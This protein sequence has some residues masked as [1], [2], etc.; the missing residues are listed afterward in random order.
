MDLVDNDSQKTRQL[1]E[2]AE[3]QE[4]FAQE[5]PSKTKMGYGP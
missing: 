3:N 5:T 1:G 2:V 4:H